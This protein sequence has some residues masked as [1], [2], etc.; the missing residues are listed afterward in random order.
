MF[1]AIR[2]RQST[3]VRTVLKPGYALAL[4]TLLLGGASDAVVADDLDGNPNQSGCFQE[5][6]EAHVREQFGIY[7]PQSATREYFGF[8]Y[9][10]NGTIESAVTRS[11]ECETSGKCIVDSSEAGALIPRGSKV[12]GEWH[13]HPHIEGSSS[14]SRED[15]RGAYSNRHIGAI[16][17]T[18]ANPRETSTHGTQARHPCRRRWLHGYPSETTWNRWQKPARQKATAGWI[19][20]R[21]YERFGT[22][23]LR[24]IASSN[25][26]CSARCFL[27]FSAN[28]WKR[29]SASG[30]QT[31]GRLR[32]DTTSGKTGSVSA[33]RRVPR[34]RARYRPASPEAPR[35]PGQ[36]NAEDGRPLP[37]RT[38]SAI[39]GHALRH[40]GPRSA[41]VRAR[42]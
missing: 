14:L 30:A 25:A 39:N 23:P 5:Q 10:H 29:G 2:D 28:A 8:I 19:C 27:A 21:G 15:V 33:R 7:G 6:V 36:K 31:Q 17:R 40:A 41:T 26:R 12:L 18:T 22:S 24:R 13:T 1:A 11:R 16:P 37:R 20:V 34:W 3:V 42:S 35:T 32:P 38:V 4:T 9:W